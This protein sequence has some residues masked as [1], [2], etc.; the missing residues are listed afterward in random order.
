M[1]DYHEMLM[2]HSISYR[3]CV[4]ACWITLSKVSLAFFVF[5]LMHFVELSTYAI[6]A[7]FFFTKSTCLWYRIITKFSFLAWQL[8]V[9]ITRYIVTW[10]LV[11]EDWIIKNIW[12]MQAFRRDWDTTKLK[13]KKIRTNKYEILESESEKKKCGVSS[14]REISPL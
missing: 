14:S 10:V 8:N 3:Y 9:I 7:G 11:N 12:I 6:P 1:N 5:L 13:T 2:R 4:R